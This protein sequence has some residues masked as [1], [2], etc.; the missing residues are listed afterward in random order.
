MFKLNVKPLP[1]PIKQQ[2]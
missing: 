2:V 1:T